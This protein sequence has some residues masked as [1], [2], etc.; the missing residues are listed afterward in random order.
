MSGGHCGGIAA[1]FFA[2]KQRRCLYYV[3]LLP[4]LCVLLVSCATQQRRMQTFDVRD[5]GAVGDGKTSDTSAFQKALDACK[6]AGGGT[7]HVA[8]GSYLIGSIVL[9][10]NTALQLDAQANLIGSTNAADYPLVRV[11]F[12]GEFVSGHR[13]LISAENA[14]NISIVGGSITARRI[15]P[16]KPA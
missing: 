1:Q 14:D 6:I 10:D 8:G 4:A 9:G 7:V 3:F 12:E 11:R 2:M 15:R 16:Q 5:F 13:A